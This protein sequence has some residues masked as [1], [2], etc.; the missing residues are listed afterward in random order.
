M[1]RPA[2]CNP[3]QAPA[4]EALLRCLEAPA[5]LISPP[6]TVPALRTLPLVQQAELL[7][8]FRAAPHLF[9]GQRV[10]PLLQSLLQHPLA[11]GQLPLGTALLQ[12]L[13]A[14]LQ[15]WSGTASASG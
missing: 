1:P 5:A 11:A 4:A 6:G 14:E 7:L 2:R 8:L 3:P 15:G 9:P 10:A 12:H 13:E